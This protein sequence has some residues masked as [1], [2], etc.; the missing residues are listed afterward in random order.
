MKHSSSIHL[1]KSEQDVKSQSKK[2][3]WQFVSFILASQIAVHAFGTGTLGFLMDW[4]ENHSSL[5]LPPFIPFAI[6]LG[7]MLVFAFFVVK[8]PHA[9][10]K[11]HP[12][13]FTWLAILGSSWMT[14]S[15]HELLHF[16]GWFLLVI[17]VIAVVVLRGKTEEWLEQQKPFG[18]LAKSEHNKDISY[19]HPQLLILILSK[20]NAVLPA[21]DLIPE[22]GV[23]TVTTKLK[24]PIVLERDNIR[25]DIFALEGLKSEVN[26][27][28]NGT[29][30]NWQQQLRAI[31]MQGFFNASEVVFVG[32]E[33]EYLEQALKF[34]RP[35]FIDSVLKKTHLTDFS[36][37]NI[38]QKKLIE[39][40]EKS[41]ID[42]DRIV[43]DV[44]GGY[45]VTSI[46]ATIFTVLSGIRV[47]WVPSSM[48]Y[49]PDILNKAPVPYDIRDLT[50]NLKIGE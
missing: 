49:D 24:G 42:H 31:Q 19:F 36:D 9:G 32:S 48:I 28:K 30:F 13:F 8:H 16:M 17:A 10:A 18:D 34:F 33:D 14:T 44:T 45:V 6:G 27:L 12:W 46:A 47:Q 2:F 43:I 11:K 7:L 39:I 4:P 35:Y 3:P 20:P 15:A 25:D 40:I 41:K 29:F 22:F 37:F 38:V 23:V 26:N 5:K 50:K 1:H 21:A